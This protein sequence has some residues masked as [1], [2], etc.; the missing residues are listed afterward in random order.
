M[1]HPQSVT[2]SKAPEVKSTLKMTILFVNFFYGGTASLQG[3]HCHSCTVSYLRC[4]HT[5][6]YQFV[7]SF[8]WRVTKKVSDALY[9]ELKATIY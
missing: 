2:W 4:Q 8:H 7:I 6:P 3:C 5:T 1:D 9:K